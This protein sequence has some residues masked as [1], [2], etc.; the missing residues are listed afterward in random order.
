MAGLRWSLDER[1]AIAHRARG[2]MARCTAWLRDHRIWTMGMGFLSFVATIFA[3]GTLPMSFQPT[4]DTDFSQVK[5]ETVPGSTLQQTTAITRKVA[6]M[7]AA[8]KDMVEA[9]LDRQSVV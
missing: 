7:L 6:D 8:D 3:F 1:K 4:I 5:I 9:A 2:G